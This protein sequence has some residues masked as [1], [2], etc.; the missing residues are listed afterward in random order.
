MFNYLITNGYAS[1]IQPS[2]PVHPQC[3]LGLT[4]LFYC[5]LPK[6]PDTSKIESKFLSVQSRTSIFHTFSMVR[7]STISSV[8]QVLVLI[9]DLLSYIKGPLLIHLTSTDKH[10]PP[11]CLKLKGAF[12]P[13]TKHY[14]KVHLRQSFGFQLHTDF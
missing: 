3:L 10:Q 9:T 13:K 7:F 6:P 4:I 8:F 11:I 5:C 14:V 1:K 2:K 12:M